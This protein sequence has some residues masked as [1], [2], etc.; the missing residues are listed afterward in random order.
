MGHMGNH[1]FLTGLC[2]GKN[3]FKAKRE[4]ALAPTK[5]GKAR[6]DQR[7]QL[8]AKQCF[9]AKLVTAFR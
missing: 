9:A 6:C 7:E 8:A 5:A 4:R 3:T 1:R 2:L